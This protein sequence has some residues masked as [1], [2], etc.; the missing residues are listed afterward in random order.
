MQ[1]KM[2]MAGLAALGAIALATPASAQDYR[3]GG[4]P[5]YAGRAMDSGY[6]IERL[7]LRLRDGVDSGALRPYQ[8]RRLFAELREIDFLR[9]QYLRTRGLSPW[10]AQDLEARID[11][12]RMQMRREFA[13]AAGPRRWSEDRFE[14]RDEFRRGAPERGYREDDGGAYRGEAA[15]SRAGPA[16]VETDRGERRGGE[17]GAGRP[18]AEDGRLRGGPDG[19]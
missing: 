1:T 7:R 15:G 17:R 3:R 18:G 5:A 2:L 12:L 10:E 19:R 16:P 11:T 8:A 9:A 4:E 14:D 13:V 6:Q